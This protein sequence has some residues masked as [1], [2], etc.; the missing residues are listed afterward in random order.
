MREALARGEKAK[1]L[2]KELKGRDW[3]KEERGKDLEK[4]AREAKAKAR[5]LALGAPPGPKL[6]KKQGV[7]ESKKKNWSRKIQN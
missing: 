6:E 5:M 3:G 1:T 7:K 2:A 4:E